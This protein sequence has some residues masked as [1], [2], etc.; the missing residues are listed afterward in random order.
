MYLASIDLFGFKSFAQK[1]HIN[2]GRGVTAIVG[3][4]GCGKSNIVDAVRWVLGEQ[5]EAALRSER[6]E[7]VIFG[8]TNKRRPLSLAEIS[9]TLHDTDGLLPVEYEEVTVTRRLFRSGKSEYLL[10]KSVCRLRD[11]LDLFM[12]TGIGP[13]AYS[14]MELKMVE[15]VLSDNPEQL[16]HLLDESLGITRYKMRRK[17]ALRRLADARLDRERALDILAEVERQGRALKRQVATVKAYKRLQAK[18]GRIRLALVL[19]RL[20]QLEQ[21]LAPL[22]T[23]IRQRQ[24]EQETCSTE[25]A[26][27]ETDLM[28]IET[29]LLSL[30]S[31]RQGAASQHEVAQSH[32]QNARSDLSKLDEEMRAHTWRIE[33]NEEERQKINAETGR[34]SQQVEGAQRVLQERERGLPTLQAALA[35]RRQAFALA[36]QRFREIRLLAQRARDE[37]NELREKQA[38]QIRAAEQRAASIQSL[39]DRRAELQQKQQELRQELSSRQAEL[40]GFQSDLEVKSAQLA[41]VQKECADLEARSE[42]LRNQKL[43]LERELDRN[44]SQRQQAQAQIEHLQEMH[45]RGSPLYSAGGALASKFPDAISG[46]LADELQLDERYLR[47]IETALAGMAFSRVIEAPE[48]FETIVDFLSSEKTG[49]AA[50]LVGQPPHHDIGDARVFAQ[51]IGGQALATAIEATS[52]VARWVAYFLRNV[53][54]VDSRTDLRR[55]ASQ[56]SEAGIVLVTLEG[57]LTDGRGIWVLGGV[58]EEAPRVVGLSARRSALERRLSELEEGQTEIR[59]SIAAFHAQQVEAQ[60]A[61]E[62]A[63][64]T[65]RQ[66]E[67]NYEAALRLKLQKEAQ[68]VGSDLLL[69]QSLRE[70][71]EVENQ[72]VNL[73][74]ADFGEQSDLDGLEAKV[75]L[76]QSQQHEHSQTESAA[77]EE[78]ESARTALDEIQMTQ[79][80]AKAEIAR[81]RDQLAQLSQRSEEL[82]AELEGLG[83]S[84][85][86]CGERLEALRLDRQIQGEI[87]A[88]AAAQMQQMRLKLEEF[89]SS[90][91]ELQESQRHANNQVRTCRSRLDEL[92]QAVHQAQ[93]QSVEIE[94][95]LREE[96]RKLEGVNTE[97]LAGEPA[98]PEILA[99]IERKIL[100]LEPLNLAAEKEYQELEERQTFLTTQLQDLNQAETDLQQTIA[101]LN[102]EAKERFE[103]GFER[104]KQNFQKVFLDVFEG[105][106]ADLTLSGDD[107]LEADVEL[108]AAPPGKRIGSLS[109]L[110]GGEKALT[111]ISLLFAIYL[112]KPSPFCILDEIDA[113]LDDENTMRFCR[114]LQNFSLKTQFLVITHNKRT[115]TQAQQLLG[116]TMEEEGI[117]KVVPVKLN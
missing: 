103:G 54:L 65:R 82:A 5:R 106:K 46:A 110:S 97:G 76:L 69:Q 87:V 2:F 40:T 63:V 96:R 39:R 17:E 84:D 48:H 115:M 23:I 93:L 18:A 78:R 20:N 31:E 36:D 11:L 112:E 80:R 32:Y 37:L 44:S 29:E 57:E 56:A 41:Q 71:A 28:R 7:N 74:P 113:P 99:K 16:R 38:Q 79:E 75:R 61:Y 6:M 43:L 88:Q 33:R 21:E 12:G 116:V 45:R 8:G 59:K 108:L 86:Q 95:G 62:R 10:N 85:R 1:T 111:A 25:L 104:I 114:M 107:P 4:N 105:G 42:E 90:R 55:F 72:L 58:H 73:T 92:S 91:L 3:P 81:T 24:A 52:L 66:A 117:S 109:L 26:A 68:V 30:E 34:L 51:S 13:D 27:V 53:V 83:Q 70:F 9:L 14:I 94:A 64:E 100:S 67:E 15:D 89:D 98:D 77:L 22:S 19:M 50:L 47:A 49:R 101:A 35:E 102:H 60:T